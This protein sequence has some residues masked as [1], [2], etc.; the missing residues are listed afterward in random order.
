MGLLT[1]LGNIWRA[2]RLRLR[3]AGSDE[4]SIVPILRELGVTIGEGTRIFSRKP[5]EMFGCDPYLIRIG[6]RVTIAGEV[7]FVTHVG[8]PWSVR[9][10]DPDF[11]AFGTIEVKDNAFIG[12]RTVVMPGVTIGEN[13]VVGSLSLVTKDVPPNVIAGGV[14]ARVLTTLDEF[15]EKQQANRTVVRGLS[16]EERKAVLMRLWDRHDARD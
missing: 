2:Q 3:M 5:V 8:M 15:R 6:K 4:Y 1:R 10:D 11:D 9:K 13:S 7:I 16:P 12:L 14:P